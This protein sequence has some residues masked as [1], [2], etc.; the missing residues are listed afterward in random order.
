MQKIIVLGDCIATGQDLL[1]PEIKKVKNC[2]SNF[3]G[4]DKFTEK[5][6]V[7]W[8]L[9]NNKKHSLKI[10]DV[11]RLSYQYKIH[12]EKQIAWPSFIKNCENF[13]V[14]GETFQGMHN[15]IK[16]YLRLNK[17]PDLVF[18]TDFS[19]PHRCVVVNFANKKYVVK[20]D[21][22]LLNKDQYIW[23]NQVYKIFLSKVAT[24]ELKGFRF[25]QR[26]NKKSF[27]MLIKLLKEHDI[28]F[29]FLLFHTENKY[30]TNQFIDLSDLVKFYKN[31]DGSENCLKKLHQQRVIAKK[32]MN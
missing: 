13:S 3:L 7:K 11:I 10:K 2:N 27:K 4:L 30:I 5:Q 16:N 22:N 23:S 18:I 31:K 14:A 1:L 24:Q 29:K 25:Q 15:K 26:K 9:D 6:M 21:L 12:K 20:R 28:Q 32:V 17:K 8:F 19:L